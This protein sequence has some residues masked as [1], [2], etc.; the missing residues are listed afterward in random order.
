MQKKF[1]KRRKYRWEERNS[2]RR[3]WLK[4]RLLYKPIVTVF[5]H[6]EVYVDAFYGANDGTQ[7][8]TGH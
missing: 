6:L 5:L 4:Q 1:C 7:S 3:N 8:K 2:S